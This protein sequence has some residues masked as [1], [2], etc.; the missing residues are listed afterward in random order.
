MD[1]EERKRSEVYLDQIFGAGAGARHTAFLATLPSPALRDGLH[2]Y[3]V[4]ESDAEHLSVADNYLI[5]V[6]VLCATKSYGPAG[7]F[8]KTLLHLGVPKQRIFAAVSRLEMWI[9]GV[10]AAEALGHVARAVREYEAEGLA[11]MKA[12]FPENK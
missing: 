10:P 5:G 8:A 3:H 12:W 7:M 4:L 1:D 9:G 2:R 6:C 11:S